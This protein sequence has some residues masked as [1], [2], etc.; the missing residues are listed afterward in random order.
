M[1]RKVN[2]LLDVIVESEAPS[3]LLLTGYA[4][5]EVTEV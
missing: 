3:F 5:L 4:P 1:S 2:L